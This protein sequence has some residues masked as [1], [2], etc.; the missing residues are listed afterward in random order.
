LTQKLL[1]VSGQIV[2][3]RGLKKYLDCQFYISEYI[4]I[5]FAENEFMLFN[6]EYISEYVPKEAYEVCR[7][8]RV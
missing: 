7:V 4:L 8:R 5:L 3:V 2:T 1:N 6:V